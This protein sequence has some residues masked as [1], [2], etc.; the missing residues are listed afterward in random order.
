MT[1][2]KSLSLDLA[3]PLS[4]RHFPTAANFDLA[5]SS[6]RFSSCLPIRARAR[7]CIPVLRRPALH[8]PDTWTRAFRF[9]SFPQRSFFNASEPR[10]RV[11]TLNQQ[12]VQ[13]ESKEDRRE[14]YNRRKCAATVQIY[15]QLRL[16]VGGWINA[17]V[18][19]SSSA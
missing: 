4:H 1:I 14:K 9:R 17:C 11:V 10:R 3:F 18:I 5:P 7:A 13:R 2:A 15:F 12:R 16:K 8:S 19:G 6:R